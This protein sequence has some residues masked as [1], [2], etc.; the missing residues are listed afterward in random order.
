MLF[1]L[2]S[3]YNEER[4]EQPVDR[5]MSCGQTFHPHQR[6]KRPPPTTRVS[7]TDNL[8][9]GDGERRLGM[10]NGSASAW[11]INQ[12]KQVELLLIKLPHTPDCLCFLS[13][14]IPSETQTKTSTTMRDCDKLTNRFENFSYPSIKKRKNKNPLFISLDVSVHLPPSPS[15]LPPLV[16]PQLL[17]DC[18]TFKLPHK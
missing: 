7:Q 18:V 5:P 12:W 13:T 14:T 15:P 11:K 1:L 3:L 8:V 9:L 16:S 10:L 2:Q 17:L 4:T 6:E